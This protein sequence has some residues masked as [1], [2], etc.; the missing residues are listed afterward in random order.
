MRKS[1]WA[2]SHR[3][4]VQGRVARFGNQ[5]YLRDVGD[6]MLRW[7]H[8]GLIVVQITEKFPPFAN[9]INAFFNLTFTVVPECFWV[10]DPRLMQCRHFGGI[11]GTTVL[12]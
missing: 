8:S 12:V 3:R 5:E 4:G 9:S 1:W 11:S 2:L 10:W 7:G 6:L